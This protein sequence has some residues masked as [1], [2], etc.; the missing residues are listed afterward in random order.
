V[1]L[2]LGAQGCTAT[3]VCRVPDPVV[4]PAP[5]SNVLPLSV[6]VRLASSGSP[7]VVTRQMDPYH[8]WIADA[9]PPTL[10]MFEHLAARMFA[11]VLPAPADGGPEGER[12]D[13]LVEI[14]LRSV[15]FE[16]APLGPYRSS[17]AYTVTLRDAFGGEIAALDV[18]GQAVR[19]ATFE[20]ATHCRGIGDCLA[21]AMQDAGA[22]FLARFPTE[23]RVVAWLDG[24]GVVPSAFALRP[25]ESHPPAARD[26]AA[27]AEGEVPVPPV[28]VRPPRVTLAPRALGVRVSLGKLV[29]ERTPGLEDARG[30]LALLLGAEVR[31]RR[32][33]GV[34][35]EAGSLERSYSSRTFPAPGGWVVLGDRA[36]A[37]SRHA[38]VGLRA[39]AAGAAAEGWAGAKL[40]FLRTTFCVEA[41]QLGFPGCAPP[42]EEDWAAGIEVGAGVDVVARGRH[43]VGIDVRRILSRARFGAVTGEVR[44]GGTIIGAT[45]TLSAP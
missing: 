27:P 41:S 26:E 1:A 5:G 6:A 32:W 10:A 33:L 25:P 12:P 17:V 2:A 44:L 42:E 13:A 23:P 29:P 8:R 38:G 35:V 4:E 21:L 45:Y 20:L 3:H 18:E 37:R 16:L 22:A 11:R 31:P 7:A 34:E 39:I 30:G 15:S 14:R 19:G 40:L 9:E 36:S 43:A 28:P 24:R